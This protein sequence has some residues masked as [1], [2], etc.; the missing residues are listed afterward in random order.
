M[1]AAVWSSIINGARG[2]V[3]FAANF[4]GPCPS[5]NLLRDHCGDAIRPGLTAVNQQIG[6]LAPVLNAPF[7]DGYA[8]SDGPVDIAVKRYEGSNYVLVG[9]TQD[10]PSDPTITLACS[11]AESAEVIDENRSVPITNRSFRDA[12][13][14]GNA[15]H[16]YKIDGTDDCGPA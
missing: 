2:I 12:F 3:Y 15:V 14:D 1:R 8:R 7:L 13:A 10:E 11:D 5:Y 9:A 16:L 4:G 6:R